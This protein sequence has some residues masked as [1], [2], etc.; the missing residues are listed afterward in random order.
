M[1]M[2]RKDGKM[3]KGSW[4]VSG[5]ASFGL[6]FFIA[7]CSLSAEDE[8]LTREEAVITKTIDRA[9]SV[10]SY[11][12]EG[13]VFDDIVWRDGEKEY[14]HSLLSGV[15]TFDPQRGHYHLVEVQGIND[16]ETTV[17]TDEIYENVDDIY[18]NYDH[19]GWGKADGYEYGETEYK[20][21]INL[22]GG[23]ENMEEITI[24]ETENVYEVSYSALDKV[25]YDLYE[26]ALS[27]IEDSIFVETREPEVFLRINKADYT[28]REFTTKFFYE[29]ETESEAERVVKIEF[30]F[31]DINEIKNIKIPDE[32]I[33]EAE[34][35]E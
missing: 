11:K 13:G 16:T 5:Y 31:D 3:K 8:H 19:E 1:V 26:P 29:G 34:Q 28:V 18:V 2:S 12:V 4:R 35:N 6:L 10:N 9:E 33:E 27:V 30:R 24:E 21:A 23:I 7:A 14:T 15:A 25:L 32:V 17:F 22:L 20:A